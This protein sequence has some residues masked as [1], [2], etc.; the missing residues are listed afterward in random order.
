MMD[1]ALFSGA[2]TYLSGADGEPTLLVRRLERDGAPVLYI[3]GATFPSALSVGY[4]FDGWSWMDDLA[5]RGFD[6]WAF[7]FAGYGGS[8]RPPGFALPAESQAPIGRTEEAADQIARVVDDIL[9]VTGRSQISLIAHSWGSIAA[10]LFAT[11]RPKLIDRLVL[12][13]P[14]AQRTGES[15]NDP[16]LVR[17]WRLVSVAQ[18][19]ARFVEDVPRGHE[20]VLIEP[21]LA[22]W[23]PAYLATDAESAMRSPPSVRIPSGPQA[24]IIDAWSGRLAYD[25]AR[26][27][28]PTLIVRGEWDSL[29]NDA[30]AAWLLACLGCA[31]KRDVKIPEGTHLMHLERGRKD[32]LEAVGVFLGDN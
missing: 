1:D 27:T 14:I 20:S 22:Q 30:D 7:D 4:R 6:V 3:H 5:H 15:P 16:A 31:R 2:A 32:L 11:R 25:P 13:G 29:T 9:A 23:G 21:S 12:F 28:A 26:I 18:Q 8:D 10:G 17:G 24:D 19:L